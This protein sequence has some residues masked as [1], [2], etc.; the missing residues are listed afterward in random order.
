MRRNL[1][2]LFFLITL[3][4]PVTS[5]A[6]LWSGIISPS[7]AVDWTQAGFPGD[8][9]PDSGWTQCATTA[10][11]TVTSAGASATAAQINSA[12]SSAPADSYVLLPAGTYTLSAGISLVGLSNVVLRGVGANQTFLTFSSSPSRVGCF[13]SMIAVEG[14][15]EYANGGETNVCNWTSGYSQGSTTITLANCGSTTPAKGSISNLK[16]G[17]ILFLDQ[18][19]EVNDTGTIW[20]CLVGTSENE[21]TSLPMCAV[22]PTGNGGGGRSN[23]TCNG[24]ECYRSQQQGVTVTSCDGITTTGHV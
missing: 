10:C 6:Q 1:S 16:V 24:A 11:N 12:L 15:C 2:L 18:L 14:G 20:N 19:D 17:S 8:T 7:R 23:G 9:L 4:L 21:S 3:C 13:A 22:N 5:Y